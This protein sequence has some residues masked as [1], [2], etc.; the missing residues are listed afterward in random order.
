MTTEEVLRGCV[1]RLDIPLQ[2]TTGIRSR[3]IAGDGEYSTDLA[4]L[5]AR[6]CFAR[7]TIRPDRVDLLINTGISR[8]DAVGRATYE[9]AAATRLRHLLGCRN[10][11]TF[12]IA[13]ACAGNFTGIYLADALIRAGQIATA[14]VVSGE[15]ISHL[16]RTAQL[17]IDGEL[18]PRIACLT[19]G[20]AGTAVLLTR[21]DD[22]RSGFEHIAIRTIGRYHELCVAGPTAQPHGGVI[23]TTDMTA[24]AA[25]GVR[26]MV[27]HAH[28]IFAR[29]G[30]TLAEVDR[31]VPH[32]TSGLAIQAAVRRANKVFGGPFLDS[33]NVIDNLAER[34]NTSTTT[35]IV[36][37]SDA[38]RDGRIESWQRLYFAIVGSGIN[39]GTALYS[40]DDLPARLATGTVSQRPAPP[41]VR[42]RR[43]TG[44]PVP[45]VG[46]GLDGPVVPGTTDTLGLIR[47]ATSACLA[48]A[49]RR[50]SDIELL[51]HTGVYR[52]GMLTE[53]AIASI[54]AGELGFDGSTT[55]SR[56]MLGFDLT[57]G[58][59]GAFDACR[60]AC[61]LIRAGE[62]R[63]ALIATS[64]VEQ[65]EPTDA[66]PGVAH[67]GS[68]LLLAADPRPGG[69]APGSNGSPG[70]SGFVGFGAR[71]FDEQIGGFNA[72]A[73]QRD[74]RAFI[75][76]DDRADLAA[77]FVEYL[78]RAV[79]GIL[80]ELE[81]PAEAVR[82][83]VP[84]SL[85]PEC[86]MEL[87]RGWPLLGDRLVGPGWP[88]ADLFTSTLPFAIG[89]LRS[90]GMV[91]R[92]D[93]V[94]FVGAASGVEI[95]VALYRF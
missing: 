15:F 72:W 8:I 71:H 38:S 13:N 25:V 7:S 74:G 23:M 92:G 50:P 84:P 61:E 12:D 64:E 6:D 19:L 65:R 44:R 5:A 87:E 21:A 66:G 62:V 32:Q 63:N 57:N 51:I 95:G 46:L 28:R 53:P 39:I 55:P 34:G 59:L 86:R 20:D 77:R 24:L 69:G 3:R 40:L 17:E 14:L 60:V 75:Y 73:A 11:W 76:S 91:E 83:V 48:E 90:A 43:A 81:T 18:D 54:A 1:R 80:D 52:T 78:P 31:F 10:A 82:L 29:R 70:S 94:A 41:P 93:L 42:A 56:T 4:E 47:R 9:P 37:L 35:H 33:R 30:R 26:E 2:E 58:G 88:D 16:M 45:V 79:A 85:P 67:C 27:A 36:A 68:A 89:R 49:G 22:D